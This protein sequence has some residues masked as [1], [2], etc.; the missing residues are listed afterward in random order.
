[1]QQ[2]FE[3]MLY[4][5]KVDVGLWAH[6]HSY[7][8]T[9]KV[10]RNECREDGILHLVIGSGGQTL[11]V[12]KWYEREWSVFHKDD[13]GYGRFSVKNSTHMFFE[14]VQNRSQKVIDSV[15]VIRKI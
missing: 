13:Y 6:Y 7:E 5:Y 9:C 4:E 15:W 14:F 10:Y 12:D 11:D 8:R 1:M 2:Y 3:D